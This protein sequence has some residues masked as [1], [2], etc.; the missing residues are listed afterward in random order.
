MVDTCTPVVRRSA[1]GRILVK[2]EKDSTWFLLVMHIVM[3]GLFLLLELYEIY[4]QRK[5]IGSNWVVNEKCAAVPDV[6][7]ISFDKF[8]CYIFV[9]ADCGKKA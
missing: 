9:N 1:R 7:V 2:N 8:K 3:I 6:G 5:E 4:R